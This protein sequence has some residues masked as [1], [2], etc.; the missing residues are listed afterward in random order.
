[1]H[2]VP[3]RDYGSLIQGKYNYFQYWF[4]NKCY[5]AY[6]YNSEMGLI[7]KQNEW[8]YRSTDVLMANT[9]HTELSA[10]I[11]LDGYID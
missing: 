3:F 1:M 2:G 10:F 9:A 6:L 8:I 11:R 7:K 5:S 4:L